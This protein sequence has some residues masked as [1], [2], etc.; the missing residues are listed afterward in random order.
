MAENLKLWFLR[1]LIG[2]KFP[3]WTDSKPSRHLSNTESLSLDINF[4]NHPV[5]YGIPQHATRR[6]RNFRR[7]PQALQRR[8]SRFFTCISLR[9]HPTYPAEWCGYSD[10]LFCLV[11]NLYSHADVLPT[12]DDEQAH[13]WAYVPGSGRS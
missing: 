12:L 4:P 9:L 10:I 13:L 1:T 5:V 8:I 7:P 6:E 3:S 2:K 11:R